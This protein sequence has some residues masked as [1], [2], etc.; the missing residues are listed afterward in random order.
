MEYGFKTLDKTPDLK[1]IRVLLRL[2]LNL[3]IV[4][5]VISQDFRL[6]KSMQ[7]I[8]YLKQCGAKTL[9]LSHIENKETSSLEII[10]VHL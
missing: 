10:F 9:L 2:D 3:P 1:D 8:E 5:G 6:R 4:N 7:T